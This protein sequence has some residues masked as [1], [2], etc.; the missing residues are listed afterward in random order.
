M[1]GMFDED[2]YEKLQN[3]MEETENQG[4][5]EEEIWDESYH[6]EFPNHRQ[7]RREGED[8]NDALNA[9]HN[10]DDNFVETSS[11]GGHSSNDTS[12]KKKGTSTKSKKEEEPEEPTRK[13]SMVD[14]IEMAEALLSFHAW[15]KLGTHKHGR[16]A[17][18]DIK[19]AIARM[20]TMVRYYCPRKKGNGWKI[21]KFHD[22]LHLAVD[23]QR[24]GCPANFDAGPHESGLCYWAK[25]PAMTA[26]TRGYNCFAKQVCSRLY[27]FQCFARAR[28]LLKIKGVRDIH[29][30]DLSRKDDDMN[31]SESLPILGGQRFFIFD[32][33]NGSSQIQA[34]HFPPSVFHATETGNPVSNLTVHPVL[35]TFLRGQKS[36]A[37]EF[38]TENQL[39][40]IDPQFSRRVG[41]GEEPHKLW[42][43]FTECKLSLQQ[44]RQRC[45]TLRCHPDF[46]GEGP[47]YDWVIAVI[48]ALSTDSLRVVP[49]KILAFLRSSPKEPKSEKEKGDVFL[50]VHPCLGK[51]DI[52]DRGK[53]CRRTVCEYGDG[54]SVLLEFF[55]LDYLYSTDEPDR[56]IPPPRKNSRP[57][58]PWARQTEPALLTPN[59]R[60]ISVKQIKDTCL[61]IEENP[62]IHE[63]IQQSEKSFRLLQSVAVQSTKD[64]QEQKLEE[65][66][67]DSSV[68]SFFSKDRVMAVRKRTLW[69]KKFV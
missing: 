5:S 17:L 29:L 27:E 4:K 6:A 7:A 36:L 54:A 26:Q 18:Q 34:N 60:I 55:H 58:E 50:I 42:Q 9:V 67:S 64:L 48:P 12:T 62:G 20:L 46:R 61:V 65:I 11:R 21:Q 25:L 31:R 15:Y 3:I 68:R 16:E 33:A 23:M 14:F 2:F 57:A 53:L 30:P 32:I 41:S 59:L 8:E 44:P 13:C 38:V 43:L 63:A 51:Q 40:R 49:C 35:E 69:A 10:L 47:W 1:Q 66:R 45:V 37:E 39:I 19:K 28:R 22:L 24:F 52:A 56:P